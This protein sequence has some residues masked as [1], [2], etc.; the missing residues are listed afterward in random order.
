MGEPSVT[1]YKC[2]EMAFIIFMSNFF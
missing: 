1:N 2:I